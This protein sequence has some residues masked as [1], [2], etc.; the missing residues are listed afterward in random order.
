MSFMFCSYL[1]L[2][3]LSLSECSNFSTLS[4]VL[5]SL[6]SVYYILLMRFSNEFFIWVIEVCISRTSIWFS[7]FLYIYWILFSYITLSS[8]FH[9]TVYILFQFIID[10]SYNYSFEFFFWDFC[11]LHLSLKFYCWFVDP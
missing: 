7:R 4:S 11:P 9:S 3:S 1:V 8:L 5:V 2:F 10:Y 6:F